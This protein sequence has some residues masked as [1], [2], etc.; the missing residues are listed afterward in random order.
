MRSKFWQH[1][2]VP[3]R[4]GVF[5]CSMQKGLANPNAV[6][7]HLMRSQPPTAGMQP[8]GALAVRSR[9]MLLDT[10]TLTFNALVTLDG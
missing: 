9:C 4:A 1:S 10:A 3:L 8:H 6:M 7:E 2:R 5:G